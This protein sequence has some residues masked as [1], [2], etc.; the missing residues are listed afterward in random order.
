MALVGFNDSRDTLSE[1]QLCAMQGR[2]LGKTSIEIA[3]ITKSNPSTV[4]EHIRR[5]YAKIRCHSAKEATDWLVEH[6]K[7]LDEES[8]I[9]RYTPVTARN[10]QAEDNPER[11]ARLKEIETALIKA[12]ETVNELVGNN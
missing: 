7:M 1:K 4:Q 6:D 9:K 3:K 8:Y 11:I 2:A 5:A 10:A 12:M